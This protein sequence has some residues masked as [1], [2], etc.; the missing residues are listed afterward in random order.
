MYFHDYGLL[1]VKI[2]KIIVRFILDLLDFFFAV[3]IAFDWSGSK[4]MQTR[5]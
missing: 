4:I 2:A 1:K 5:V 3:E